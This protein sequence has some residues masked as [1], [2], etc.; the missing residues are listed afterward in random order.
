MAAGGHFHFNNDHNVS[1]IKGNSTL[2]KMTP[3][4][5]RSVKHFESYRTFYVLAS[6][7][8]MMG[9]WGV[10]RISRNQNSREF[11]PEQNDAGLESIS[12]KVQKVTAFPNVGLQKFKMAAGGQNGGIFRCRLADQFLLSRGLFVPKGMF[13][14][15]VVSSQYISLHPDRQ[16][17]IRR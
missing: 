11:S 16:T 17:D 5:C 10:A 15:F 6:Y 14:A 8:L 13:V 7:H 2:N 12:Q 4:W 1:R 9:K 3:V